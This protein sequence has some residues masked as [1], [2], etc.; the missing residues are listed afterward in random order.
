MMMSG[1]KRER[2]LGFVTI[3]VLI[4]NAVLLLVVLS[5]IL[6][7]EADSY[8]NQHARLASGAISGILLCVGIL[9]KSPAK[10]WLLVA[11]FASVSV[12]VVLAVK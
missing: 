6:R 4:L 8:H 1:W 10:G 2:F 3:G 9:A 12:S 11:A 7:G 5:D